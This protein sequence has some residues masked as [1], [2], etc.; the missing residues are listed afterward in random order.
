MKAFHDWCLEVS[1]ERDIVDCIGKYF[2]IEKVT[3]CQYLTFDFI[4]HNFPGTIFSLS[5]PTEFV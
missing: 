3:F 5:V 4:M 2:L 1:E